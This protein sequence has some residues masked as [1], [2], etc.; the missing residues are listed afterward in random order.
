MCFPALGHPRAFIS[1]I[2]QRRNLCQREG[3]GNFFNAFS[4]HRMSSR[5]FNKHISKAKLYLC[6]SYRVLTFFPFSFSFVLDCTAAGKIKKMVESFW[7]FS[8]HVYLEA[9][10]IGDPFRGWFQNR[11]KKSRPPRLPLKS[12][13]KEASL[14]LEREAGLN[15]KWTTRSVQ[16]PIPYF[17][18]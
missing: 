13:S 9:P 1:A 14:E 4:W 10:E 5:D 11:L 17:M 18:I 12:K 2:H 8:V 15:P 7:D 16:R 3:T 6:P